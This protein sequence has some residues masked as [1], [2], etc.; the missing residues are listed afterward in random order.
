MKT[1]TKRSRIEDL[2]EQLAEH[3]K[4]VKSFEAQAGDCDSPATTLEAE[5]EALKADTVSPVDTIAARVGELNAK[6]SVLRARAVAI[7]ARASDYRAEHQIE[8]LETEHRALVAEQT[9]AAERAAGI[10]RHA[11]LVA[12]FEARC[13]DL[14]T[15]YLAS[16]ASTWRINFVTDEIAA[17]SR[18]YGLPEPQRMVFRMADLEKEVRWQLRNATNDAAKREIMAFLPK[19][20]S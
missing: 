13:A 3:H 16:E 4:A 20:D 1:A 10:A 14:K 17:L 15:R 12:E 9:Q 19:V 8:G 5:I 11:A 2:A 18:R 6:A 7:R